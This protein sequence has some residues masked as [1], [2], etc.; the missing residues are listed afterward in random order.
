MNDDIAFFN[1]V[2]DI[3]K[4]CGASYAYHHNP[5]QF[6]HNDFMHFRFYHRLQWFTVGSDYCQQRICR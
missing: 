3:A 1:A 2:L 6:V 4:T 5:M